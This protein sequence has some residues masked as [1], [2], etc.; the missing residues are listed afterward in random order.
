MVHKIISHKKV[1]LIFFSPFLNIKQQN[2][3][4]QNFAFNYY[5]KQISDM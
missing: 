5:H 3:S 2:I 4:F 1:I